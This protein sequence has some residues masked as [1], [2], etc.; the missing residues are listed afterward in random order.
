MIGQV[1]KTIVSDWLTNVDDLSASG[2][3]DVGRVYALHGGHHSG[4]VGHH[5]GDV[6]L[7]PSQLVGGS[8]G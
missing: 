7:S 2:F 6:L 3:V 8:R 4:D 1:T 5:S